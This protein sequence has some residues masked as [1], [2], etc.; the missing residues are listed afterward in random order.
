M[1]S[2]ATDALFQRYADK[3]GLMRES[4]LANMLLSSGLDPEMSKMLVARAQWLSENYVRCGGSCLDYM[5]F[6]P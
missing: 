3:D 1:N 4:G 2:T 5:N 6:K